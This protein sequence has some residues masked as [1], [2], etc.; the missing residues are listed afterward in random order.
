MHD[1]NGI[2]DKN[3]GWYYNNDV[4]LTDVSFEEAVRI[5]EKELRHVSY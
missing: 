1:Y 2:E 5:Y 3:A 4:Y